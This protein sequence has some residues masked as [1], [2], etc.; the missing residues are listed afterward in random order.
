M[1]LNRILSGFDEV[2]YGNLLQKQTSHEGCGDGHSAVS[3]RLH[4]RGI[5]VSRLPQRR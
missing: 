3:H 5:S 4:N 2:R 1:S